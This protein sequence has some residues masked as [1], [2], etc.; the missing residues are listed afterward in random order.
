[1]YYYPNNDH[2]PTKRTIL[3]DELTIK[4]DLI[5]EINKGTSY[6]TRPMLYKKYLNSI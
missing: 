6:I 2:F 5:R 3:S 4:P 1:M